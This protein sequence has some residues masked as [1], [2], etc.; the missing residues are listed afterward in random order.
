MLFGESVDDNPVSSFEVIFTCDMRTLLASEQVRQN[1]TGRTSPFD[2][3]FLWKQRFIR[4]FD[5]VHL[6]AYSLLPLNNHFCQYKGAR[7]GV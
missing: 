1:I 2:V 3:E 5:I 6:L 7:L 4:I